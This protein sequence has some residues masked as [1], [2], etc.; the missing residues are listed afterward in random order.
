MLSWFA[1]FCDTSM[2]ERTFSHKG[3][4]DTA[5]TYQL[6]GAKRC[7]DKHSGAVGLLEGS[8][9]GTHS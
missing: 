1:H 8:T 6:R 3:S 7:K 2:L 9:E 5:H 4:R